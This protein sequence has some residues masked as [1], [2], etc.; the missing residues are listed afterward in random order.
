ML[1]YKLLQ[2]FSVFFPFITEEIYQDIYHDMKSIHITEIKPLNYSFDNEMLNGDLMCEII[3][4]V[5]GEKSS[6]NLSLKTTVK[7]LDIDCS[8]GIKDAIE[9]SKKDF[10]ATLFIE[11]LILNDIEKDYKINNITLDIEKI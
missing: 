10:K 5:R 1:L 6:N 9:Q 7:E 3:G 8:A 11:N 2:D 4:A